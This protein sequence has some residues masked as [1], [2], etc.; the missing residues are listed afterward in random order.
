MII[1]YPLEYSESL[2]QPVIWGGAAAVGGGA[3]HRFERIQV[4][5]RVYTALAAPCGVVRKYFRCGTCTAR[6]G[7]FE[8]GK[9]Q[10]YRPLHKYHTHS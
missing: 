7:M 2:T 1:L 3:V 6:T 5:Q 9:Q 4:V 10:I 8:R